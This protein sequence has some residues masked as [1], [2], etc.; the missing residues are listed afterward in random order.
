MKPE[1]ILFLMPKNLDWKLPLV[2]VHQAQ[3]RRT[4]RREST[5]STP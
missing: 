4:S 1:Q 3:L 5:E 2:E